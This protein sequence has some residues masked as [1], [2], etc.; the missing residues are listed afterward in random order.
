MLIATALN[1]ILS[2]FNRAGSNVLIPLPDEVDTTVDNPDFVGWNRNRFVRT[3][4]V[5][6]HSNNLVFTEH[7][8]ALRMGIRAPS[9]PFVTPG[10]PAQNECGVVAAAA[11][12]LTGSVRFAFRWLDTLHARRSPLSAASQAIPLANQGV[13]FSGVP[14]APVPDDPCVD[15]IEVWASV[16]GGLFRHLA[17]RDI[18]VPTFT[19]NEALTGEAYDTTQLFPKVAFGDM[20]NDRFFAAGNLVHPDRVYISA[21]G[22]PEEYQ[23][24][25]IPTRN[26]EPVTGIKNIGGTI[27]VQC[28][29]SCYYIQGFG[30]SDITMKLLKGKIGGYGQKSIILLD[31]VALIPAQRAWFR[32]DG[33]SMVPTG[34]GVW[35][36][37][38]RKTVADPNRRP[39]YEG[40]FGVADLVSGVVK[41]LPAHPTG[42]QN[43]DPDIIGFPS[44]AVNSYW[45]INIAG[46]VPDIGGQGQADL[47]FD[48]VNGGVH[49]C[50]AM[51]F[52]PDA[53]IGELY[54]GTAEGDILLE[55][56]VGNVDK[57]T[58]AS[59]ETDI[60]ITYI[61][62]TP[63]PIIE[64]AF[65]D[66]DSSQVTDI[67]VFFQCEN[68]PATL[69]VYAG[70]EFAWQAGAPSTLA[71]PAPNTFLAPEVFTIP[72]GRKIPPAAGGFQ[73][74]YVPRDRFVVQ[75]LQKSPGTCVSIR[76]TVTQTVDRASE[77]T[78]GSIHQRS[79]VVFYGWGFI[80]Q[81]GQER[82]PLAVFVE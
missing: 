29:T 57:Q 3:Y 13:T 28:R 62:H 31:D 80:A 53:T 12:G 9:C 63:H 14:D 67:C 48:N 82:R 26:G 60:P 37:T 4:I 25:Y 32:C 6:G 42:S 41:F 40:G 71:V 73:N 2:V 10:P 50:A 5:G 81:P 59:V 21:L 11:P 24:L 51:L 76:L 39:C 33:T 35:D 1:G 22:N 15:A 7:K 16:D 72:A 70:N 55:N 46:V 34:G 38:W 69:G 65:S 77:V 18:G 79:E 78:L 54:T 49:T 19:V 23:G 56:Q 30:A 58:I 27:Y 64:P 36:D 66:D 44:G 8:W 61:V 20:A 68:L 43:D 52:D 17:T 75:S 45:I 74:A 47:S